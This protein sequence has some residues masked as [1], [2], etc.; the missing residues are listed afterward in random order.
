MDLTEGFLRSIRAL[1]RIAKE[2]KI[3]VLAEGGG[4]VDCQDSDSDQEQVSKDEDEQVEPAAPAT[5]ID[6]AVVA[7]ADEE[8]RN[9]EDG[10]AATPTAV[11]SSS[12]P[13]GK[14][15]SKEPVAIRRS[16]RAR[17]APARWDD[18]VYAFNVSFKQAQREF[19]Q[20]A[21]EQAVR[22][23]LRQIHNKG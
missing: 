13:R 3:E 1:A 16:T 9:E 22:M 8:D 5:D 10:D 23:E 19:G 2:P 15:R 18:D 17:S 21:S 4:K 20:D 6:Q 14:G 7:R 11:K 12:M